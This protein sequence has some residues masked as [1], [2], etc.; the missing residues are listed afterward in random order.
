MQYRF[1]PWCGN[2]LVLSIKTRNKKNRSHCPGCKF[3]HYENPKPCVGAVIVKRGKILLTRRA[4]EPYQNYW[5]FPGGFLESGENPKR[6]LS[7]EL[8]EELQIGVKIG[9]VLG[10]YPDYYGPGGDATLNIYYLCRM[11]NGEIIPR[12]GEIAEAK[13]FAANAPPVKLAFEHAPLVI[14]AWRKLGALKRSHAVPPY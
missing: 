11:V 13:W 6:G 3:I 1:C 7:R 8:K 4:Y 14:K 2:K 9:R 5:D 10:I 12:A